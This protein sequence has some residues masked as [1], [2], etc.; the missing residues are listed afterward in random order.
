MALLP[1]A[2]AVPAGTVLPAREAGVQ[3]ASLP[4]AAAAAVVEAASAAPPAAEGLP[5]PLA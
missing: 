5:A 4:G 3:G 2:E 1:V